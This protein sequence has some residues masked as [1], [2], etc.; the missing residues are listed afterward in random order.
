MHPNLQ[1][2][3]GEFSPISVFHYRFTDPESYEA[4]FDNVEDGS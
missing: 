1:M 4:Y 2:V 3:R